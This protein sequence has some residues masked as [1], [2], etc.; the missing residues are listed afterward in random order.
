[1]LD[2]RV[3]LF[4]VLG[5]IKEAIKEAT[6]NKLFLL[7]ENCALRARAICLSLVSARQ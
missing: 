7:P 4:D 5:K 2:H 1:M 3:K 6:K